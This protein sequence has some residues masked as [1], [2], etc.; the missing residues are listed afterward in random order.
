MAKKVYII[1]EAGVNHNGD[2][3]LAKKLVDIAFE[4]GVDYIKFQTY[5]TENIVSKI[6]PMAD[7]QQKNLG[8][9]D[10]AQFGMLK[11]IELSHK[12]HL[13]IMS[14]CRKK[15]IK[16]LSTGADLGSIEFLYKSGIRIFKIASGDITNLPFLR[17]IG[18]Y[19]VEVILS[20][21]MS[22]L[23]DIQNA[24]E[25]LISSGTKREKITILHCTSE[26]PAPLKDVN[27]LAI[28]TLARIFNLKVGYSDHTLGIEIPIV[29]VALGA[30][31]IEKHFTINR[32]M[33]GP[34]HKASLEPKE[35]KQMV[36]AI[37]K[38]EIAMGD[39]IKRV[40]PA[41]S[42]NQ[43]IT[44]KGIHLK[45]DLA[46]LHKLKI[47]DLVMMRPGDGISPMFMDSIVNRKLNKAFKKNHKLQFEDLS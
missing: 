32:D 38:V 26:Y 41:E 10:S 34:D 27:L 19:Q 47:S 24:L 11:K 25:I 44:R 3:G 7:Y 35:L 15:G 23:F 18:S 9:K 37:R 31:I 12:E 43:V 46:K 39:G 6:A 42:K 22:T 13:E 29:A 36:K 4:A 8:V 28:Q 30:T 20:T 45:K 1:G 5:K 40:S 33:D 16:Y 14:Y 21:G 2:V 17:K